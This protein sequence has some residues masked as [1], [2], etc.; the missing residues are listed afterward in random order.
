MTKYFTRY[1][2][3][4]MTLQPTWVG[5]VLFLSATYTLMLVLAVTLI[6][7]VGYT[8]AAIG[9]WTLSPVSLVILYAFYLAI[10]QKEKTNGTN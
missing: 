7:I 5:V 2:D 6:F 4:T 3:W 10:F 9:L 8:W 1:T